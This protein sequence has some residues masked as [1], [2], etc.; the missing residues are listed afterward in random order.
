M[1]T[2]TVWY[3]AKQNPEITEILYVQNNYIISV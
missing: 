3:N 1:Y 2:E